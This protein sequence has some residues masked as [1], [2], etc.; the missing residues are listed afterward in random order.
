MELVIFFL[1][2]ILISILIVKLGIGEN[3]WRILNLKLKITNGKLKL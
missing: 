1:G 2:T 3:K